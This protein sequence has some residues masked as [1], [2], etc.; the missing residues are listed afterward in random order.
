[1][2]VV[3]DYFVFVV[4]FFDVRFDFYCFVVCLWVVGGF[5]LFRWCRCLDGVDVRWCRC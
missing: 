4:D 5:V 2:F 3:M 1:L